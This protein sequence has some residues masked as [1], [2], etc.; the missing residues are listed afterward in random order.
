MNSKAAITRASRWSSPN[1]VWT[2][3]L[4]PVKL[5]TYILLLNLHQTLGRW[6]LFYSYRWA[7]TGG[8]YSIVTGEQVT[9]GHKS[10]KWW[11]MC[12][13]VW[14]YPSREASW[15]RWPARSSEA[16]RAHSAAP[17]LKTKLCNSFEC[18][19]IFQCI[20]FSQQSIHVLYFWLRNPNLW[21]T[22]FIS[23]V[24]PGNQFN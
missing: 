2:M 23:D 22:L 9:Q 17:S 21:C 10:R 4:T 12:L 7:N 13:T 5:S 18:K 1:W 11:S 3:F 6:V 14:I 16:Q 19:D 15:R 8:Y 20:L 24:A